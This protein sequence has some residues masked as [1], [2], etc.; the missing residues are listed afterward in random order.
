MNERILVVNTHYSRRDPAGAYALALT[1]LLRRAGYP[2]AEFAMHHPDNQ[3]SEWSDYYAEPIPTDGSIASRLRRTLRR[4]GYDDVATSFLALLNDFRP[5]VVH[6]IDLHSGLSTRLAQLARVKGCR[7]VWTLLTPPLPP[8][9]VQR[10]VD[11]FIAPSPF[12]VNELTRAGF[13]ADKI[14]TVDP[15]YTGEVDTS[16]TQRGQYYCYVGPLS[17]EADARTLLKAATMLRHEL[18]IAGDGPLAPAL[19]DK[20]GEWPQITFLGPLDPDAQARLLAQAACA[21]VTSASADIDP[22]E[23][24]NPLILGTPLVATAIGPLPDFVDDD[25]GITVPPADHQELASAIDAAYYGPWP[26]HDIARRAA[27]RFSPEAHLRAI[28]EIYAQTPR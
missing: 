27:E 4:F 11:T 7:V 23:A 10:D 20:Y 17:D 16:D 21:V 3:P 14:V 2:T 28:A 24:V 18:R 8:R 22:A 1:D 19:R 5:D 15:L 26:H 25:C 13:P 12:M 6:I 9:R